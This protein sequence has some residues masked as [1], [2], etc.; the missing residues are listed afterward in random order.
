MNFR[1]IE[2]I[3]TGNGW[4]LVRTFGFS[5]QYRKTGWETA[6]VLTNHGRETIPLGAVKNLEQATGLSFQR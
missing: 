3:L 6:V 5:R 1:Q 2:N 4:T